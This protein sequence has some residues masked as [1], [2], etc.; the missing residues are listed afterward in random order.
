MMN[1]QS[2]PQRKQQ[3]ISQEA[4]SEFLLFNM[5]DGSYYSLNEMGWRIW[6]LCDG[7]HSIARLIEIM[8][9]EYEAPVETIT[10][11]I[12]ELLGELHTCKLIVD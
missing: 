11:D 10:T 4:T 2:I 5:N 12:M 3:V 8:T 6:E 7:N 1:L 9:A